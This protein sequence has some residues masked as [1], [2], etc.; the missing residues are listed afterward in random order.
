MINL[1][2]FSEVQN[3]PEPTVLGVCRVCE[4]TIYDYELISCD[5]CQDPVHPECLVHC[6]NCDYIACSR[7]M[8]QSK[9]N[10]DYY[11]GPECQITGELYFKGK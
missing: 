11:C 7:C 10:L 8:M 6:V 9:R 3:V 1:D 5:L 2:R 4:Q